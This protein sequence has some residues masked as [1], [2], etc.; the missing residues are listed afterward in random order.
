MQADVQ[1]KRGGQA[2]ETHDRISADSG[3]AAHAVLRFG[4]GGQPA[5][6]GIRILMR[7]ALNCP[8]RKSQRP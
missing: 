1:V 8:I 6:S 5:K 4:T 7:A 2:H 3:G